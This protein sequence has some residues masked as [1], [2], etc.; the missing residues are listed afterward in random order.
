M[1]RQDLSPRLMAA[2][3]R[4]AKAPPPI[5]NWP[6]AVR[7]G[8]DYPLQVTANDIDT[9]AD[10]HAYICYVLG[11]LQERDL[12]GDPPA[13]CAAYEHAEKAGPDYSGA[14]HL[15]TAIR[16][17]TDEWAARGRPDAPAL[18]DATLR[19]LQRA[20]HGERVAD[21]AKACTGA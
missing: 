13:T 18:P 7:L 9:D 19:I 16:D 14:Y 15:L 21:A 5:P 17:A 12:P 1:H 8:V 11:N 10:A 3:D 2:F 4:L 6:R 20:A